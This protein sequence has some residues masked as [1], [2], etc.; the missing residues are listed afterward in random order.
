MRDPRLS[1]SLL[2]L[3]RDPGR[4]W[5][6]DALAAESNISRSVFADRFQ[7]VVGTAPLRYV[8]ELRMQLASQ[9]LTH[10]SLS[11]EVVAERL[12]YASQAAFSR[13]YKRVIGHSPGA[14]RRP[15]AFR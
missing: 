13:A 11:I 6:V 7:A 4:D 8:T 1:P 15:R 9:W 10:Q 12:G 2:A 3:H 14:T 5:T